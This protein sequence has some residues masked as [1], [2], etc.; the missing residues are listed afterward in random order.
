MAKIKIA[1]AGLGNCASAL[2]QGLEYY[3]DRRGENLEGIMTPRIGQYLCSDIEV[4]A[5]F[6]IDR[7]KVGYRLE[8]AIFAARKVISDSLTERIGDRMRSRLYE[9]CKTVNMVGSDFRQNM[10]A[11]YH[12]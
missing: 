3:R 8:E 5:A 11:N 9:M 6:D 10:N 1:I 7:R 4:V 2:V 12:F